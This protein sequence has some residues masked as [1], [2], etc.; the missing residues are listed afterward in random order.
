[1]AATASEFLEQWRGSYIDAEARDLE[2]LDATIAECVEEH[3][4]IGAPAISRG[5]RRDAS[6]EEPP[7]LPASVRSAGHS[8]M[9]R[10]GGRM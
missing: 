5:R 3:Y 6:H 7:G 1:M 2:Q 4:R 8:E 9:L 10:D